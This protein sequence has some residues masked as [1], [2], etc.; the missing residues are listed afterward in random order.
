MNTD[1][2]GIYLKTNM[3]AGH[4]GSSGRHDAIRENAFQMR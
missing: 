4:G 2:N 3:S 1:N